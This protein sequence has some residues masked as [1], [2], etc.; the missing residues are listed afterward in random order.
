MK[1]TNCPKCGRMFKKIVSPVCPDCEKHDE[2]QFQ[3]LRFFLEEEPLANI[4]EISEATGITPKRI[5]Q[6]IREGRL[7]IPESLRDDVR[8]LQCGKPIEEGTF[9]EPCANSLAKELTSVYETSETPEPVEEKKEPE[10]LDR[11]GVGMHIGARKTK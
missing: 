7:Q 2:E 11:R 5:L 9:C 3:K 1:V 10:K 8:C 6:Y 4:S